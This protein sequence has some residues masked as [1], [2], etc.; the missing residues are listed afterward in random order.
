MINGNKLAVQGSRFVDI[1]SCRSAVAE[2]VSI[3]CALYSHPLKIPNQRLK[4][5]KLARKWY[6]ALPY[7]KIVAHGWEI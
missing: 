6:E 5:N 1:T 4:T 3:G 2:L 7:H